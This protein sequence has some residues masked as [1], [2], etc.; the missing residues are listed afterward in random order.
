MHKQNKYGMKIRREKGHIHIP[1]AFSVYTK[2][3]AS[4]SIKS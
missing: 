4:F 2:G 3:I 1:S